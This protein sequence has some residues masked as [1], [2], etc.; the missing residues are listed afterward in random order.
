MHAPSDF[1]SSYPLGQ[2]VLATVNLHDHTWSSDDWT[3]SGNVT[4][5]LSGN[6]VH[7][8]TH[9]KNQKLHLTLTEHSFKIPQNARGFSQKP[10]M[11]A[12]FK[13]YT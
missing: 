4:T 6:D 12:M 11:E 3:V 9:T 8:C 10:C 7:N 1:K 5:V 2:T 13:L